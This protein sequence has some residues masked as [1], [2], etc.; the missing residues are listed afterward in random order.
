MFNVLLYFILFI[1]L[2]LL[3]S[4]VSCVTISET[5]CA[6]QH[7]VL[8]LLRPLESV[9]QDVRV[10]HCSR[11]RS[12]RWQAGRHKMS[13]FTLPENEIKQVAGWQAQDVRIHTTR[14]RD[15]DVRVHA[16]RERDQDVR[17]HAA[18][19]RDQDVRVHTARERNQDVRVHTARERD[20]DVRVHT[21]RGTR[22][23]RWQAAIRQFSL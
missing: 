4:G 2:F 11:T 14:E 5:D 17:V 16:A 10:S 1:Y 8:V 22:S 18:R 20:Q 7:R 9:A 21:A 13:V 19:D 15:Q 6:K 12:N 3:R 23:N